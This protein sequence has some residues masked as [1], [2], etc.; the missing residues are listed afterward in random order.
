MCFPELILG[1]RQ[2]LYLK[3]AI[4]LRKYP[5]PVDSVFFAAVVFHLS[6]T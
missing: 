3:A 4:F 1:E 5:L 6:V 2:V